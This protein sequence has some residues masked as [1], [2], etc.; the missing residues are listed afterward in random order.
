MWITSTTQTT[1]SVTRIKF[2]LATGTLFLLIV[3]R[4]VLTITNCLWLF[5]FYLLVCS[6]AVSI[7]WAELFQIG[8]WSITFCLRWSKLH[9]VPW[10]ICPF[11]SK[12][13]LVHGSECGRMTEKDKCRLAILPHPCLRRNMWVFWPGVKSPMLDLYRSQGRKRWEPSYGEEGGN[14]LAW[15][16]KIFVE[17][18]Y[19]AFLRPNLLLADLYK[20]SSI[21]A[22]SIFITGLIFV[23]FSKSYKLFDFSEK[24]V[25]PLVGWLSCP[26]LT[27]MLGSG[28]I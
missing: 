4:F 3:T 25:Q 5:F 22:W 14:G 6:A 19:I 11:I 9:V 8:F 20:Y 28:I 26:S 12:S 21:S 7:A 13:I 18:N 15:Y 23:E 17:K 1:C 27:V 2:W 24:K 10:M 16:T